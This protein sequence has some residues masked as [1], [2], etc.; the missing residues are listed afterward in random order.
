[1]F[2]SLQTNLYHVRRT[3]HTLG[4]EDF[5]CLGLA[6]RGGGRFPL[7]FFCLHAPSGWE[8]VNE[9]EIKNYIICPGAS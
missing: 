1:M 7:L 5:L 3:Q 6:R 9:M 2:F 8:T 4:A